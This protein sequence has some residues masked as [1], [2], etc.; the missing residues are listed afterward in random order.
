MTAEMKSELA[1]RII[2]F[3]FPDDIDPQWI[4]GEPE[5]AAMMNGGS[6]VMPYLEPFLNRTMREALKQVK[7]EGLR[8]DA[9]G[10]VAQ[11]GQHYRTHRRFNNLLKAKRYPELAEVEQMMVA[12]YAKLAKRPLQTRMAYTAG[13][14][15]MTLGVTKW[16]IGRRVQLFAGADPRVASF[17]LWHMVE[18]TEHKRVAYDIYAD[19]YGHSL[20]AYWA[21]MLGVFHGSLD[22]LRFSM[23][24]Y[25]VMLRKEGLWSQLRSRLRLASR[26]TAFSFHVGPFLIRAALPGHNP[27]SEKDPQWVVDW[28]D[29]YANSAGDQAPLV[30]TDAPDIPVPFSSVAARVNT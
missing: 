26:L 1:G 25:K 27:R 22:V 13:F 18:E 30:D 5:M 11:E 8:A 15:A 12:S 6:M 21:R 9:E 14:E 10:F 4:P 7:D 23:R 28:L 24:S 20:G 2:P 17:I 3:E 16:I 19:L 29:G